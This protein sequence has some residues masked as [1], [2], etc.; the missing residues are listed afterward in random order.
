VPTTERIWLKAQQQCGWC[1]TNTHNEC[2]IEIF[3]QEKTWICGCP[4]PDC[5]ARITTKIGAQPKKE[6]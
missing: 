5:R 2:K 4:K 1:I 6:E 3:G